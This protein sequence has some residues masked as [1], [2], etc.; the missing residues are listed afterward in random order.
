MG[1]WLAGTTA[2][3]IAVIYAL[4]ASVWILVSDN[5]LETFIGDVSGLT[6]AQTYKGWVFIA[7]TAL[8]LYGLLRHEF[9]LRDRAMRAAQKNAS[10]YADLARHFESA[11]AETE[12]ARREIAALLESITDAFVALDTE[13]HY[14]Y[15]NAK[16]GELLG[17]EPASLIGKYIWSEFP[18]GRDQLF[19]RAYERAATTQLAI[20][21]E[22]Y[23]APWDRCS[24]C[25]TVA[26]SLRGP[27]VR[28]GAGRANCA[29]L[30]PRWR[31]R[32]GHS[33][34]ARPPCA[35]TTGRGAGARAKCGFGKARRAAHA[36][37]RTRDR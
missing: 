23:Y 29:R 2:L 25:R 5:L 17:R 35:A 10:E 28:L 13:W 37:A 14:R 1:H 3:R 7:L 8:L 30:P 9:R 19:A 18:E 16:A 33:V 11:Q 20:Q 24:V 34:S 6:R 31:A 36:R 26:T 15:V 32:R 27:P 12:A 21:L 22:E 4:A